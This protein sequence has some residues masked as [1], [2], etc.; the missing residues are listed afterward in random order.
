MNASKQD[1]LGS[2]VSYFTA[3]YDLGVTNLVPLSAT[4]KGTTQTDWP[5]IAR[6]LTREGA[7]RYTGS[8]LGIEGTDDTTIDNDSTDKAVE[9]VFDRTVDR[10]YGAGLPGGRLTHRHGSKGS[11]VL[12]RRTGEEFNLCKLLAYEG[13]ALVGV[14]ELRGKGHQTKYIGYNP[15]LRG[16]YVFEDADGIGGVEKFLSYVPNRPSISRDEFLGDLKAAFEQALATDPRTRDRVFRVESV[17]DAG[18][19]IYKDQDTLL[20]AGGISQVREWLAAMPDEAVETRDDWLN[21][22]YASLASVPLADRPEVIDA[23]VEMSERTWPGYQA[24]SPR[25]TIEGL[26]DGPFT[27]P[28][29]YLLGQ[30]RKYGGEAGALLVAQNEFNVVPMSADAPPAAKPP[31]L[32]YRSL[33]ELTED[34]SLLKPPVPVLPKL[35]FKGRATLLAARE[36]HGKSTLLADGVVALSNGTAFLG[37]PCPQGITLWCGEEH[38]GDVVRRFVDLGANPDMIYVLDL[39]AYGEDRIDVVCKAIAAL[40]PVLVI[41]DTLISLT[42]GIVKDSSKDSQITPI[43]SRIAGLAARL[44]VACLLSHHST[45]SGS[46]YHGSMAYGALVD[47]IIEMKAPSDDPKSPTRH[48]TSNGRWR[49][50]DFTLR[51]SSVTRTYT[52]SSAMTP[53]DRAVAFIRANPGC[54]KSQLEKDL[55]VRSAGLTRLRA[56]LLASGIVRDVGVGRNWALEIS[57]AGDFG[58]TPEEAERYTLAPRVPA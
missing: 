47:C 12:L 52:L 15:E 10:K 44:D 7:A 25:A 51:F 26:G 17:R 23:F 21:V 9:A 56:D 6:S 13:T 57:P 41:I 27:I 14:I 30:I 20:A 42:A 37:E 18:I 40:R 28:A 33:R 36:K 8:Q 55:G 53:I 35:A 50:D 38:T 46:G 31:V 16:D 11:A 4:T 43:I 1:V 32:S 34:P 3:L 58:I 29:D 19:R 54:T 5:E 2:P 22:A 39:R 45:K 24:Q 48:V 49:T